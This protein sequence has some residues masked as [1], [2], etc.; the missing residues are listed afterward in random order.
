M[1]HFRCISVRGLGRHLTPKG[2]TLVELLIA[3]V[4]GGILM[5]G[6]IKLFSTE[7]KTHNTQFAV[8]SLQQNM[9]A[10]MDYIIRHTR[11]AGY[12]PAYIGA[13]FND[14]LANRLDFTCDIGTLNDASTTNDQTPNGRIDNHWNEKVVFRLIGSNLVRVKPSNIPIT[15][16][17]NIEAVNFRYLDKNGVDTTNKK[18]VRS[19]QIT[20]IGRNDPNTA[21]MTN[22]VDNKVYTNQRGDVILP[23]QNDHVRRLLLTAEVKCRNLAWN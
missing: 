14:T 15:V 5:A 1:Q 18:D 7:I 11:M 17:E 3:M 20:L 9:R 8:S 10:A 12:D 16:A 2:F 23:A 4:I 13:G 21:M 6:V 19:V 22:Y